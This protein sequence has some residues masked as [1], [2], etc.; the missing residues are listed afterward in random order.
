MD[1]QVIRLAAPA[2]AAAAGA[3]A[4][5]PLTVFPLDPSLQFEFMVKG[6]LSLTLKTEGSLNG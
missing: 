5:F 6:R 4:A 3:P 2:A 1:S